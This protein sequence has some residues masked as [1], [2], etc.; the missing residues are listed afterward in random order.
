ML[1][2]LIKSNLP[3]LKTIFVAGAVAGAAAAGT[4]CLGVGYVIGNLF[5]AKSGEDLRQDISDKVG[6]FANNF[7]GSSKSE[8]SVE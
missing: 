1:D 6:E 2:K 5:A 4:V 8:T 7:T 3:L